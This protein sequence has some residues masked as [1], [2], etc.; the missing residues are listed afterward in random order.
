MRITT[1][2]L[3][4]SKNVFEIFRNPQFILAHTGS[5]SDST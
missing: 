5:A 1:D 3:Y 2:T 4:C